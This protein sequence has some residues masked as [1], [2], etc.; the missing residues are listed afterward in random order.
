[1]QN[2]K[3]VNNNY[4]CSLKRLLYCPGSGQKLLSA[5]GVTLVCHASNVFLVLK[6]P[7]SV[8]DAFSKSM[9]GLLDQAWLAIL[10]P[11]FTNF[12]IWPRQIIN[13]IGSGSQIVSSP[14][15][16][17]WLTPRTNHIYR[18]CQTP[19]TH[20]LGE[21]KFNY[22]YQVVCVLV[23]LKFRLRWVSCTVVWF[24]FLFLANSNG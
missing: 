4:G 3:S 1:M 16:K 20:S 21:I 17:S 18:M 14:D 13:F 19:P 24:W 23:K 11:F 12:D 9:M 6:V 5:L 2:N 7:L 10:E 22:H 8:I 15:K